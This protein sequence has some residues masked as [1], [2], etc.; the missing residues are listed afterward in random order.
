M[1]LFPITD[2]DS[3]SDS[4]SDFGSDSGSDLP[5]IVDLVNR[6]HAVDG[7]NIRIEVDEFRQELNSSLTTM[8]RDVRVARDGSGR[9]LGLVWTLY[10]PSDETPSSGDVLQRCYVEGCVDPEFRGRGLGRELLSWGVE[11][12]RELLAD[13]P[14]GHRVIRVSRRVDNESAA[15]LHQRF[16]FVDVRW[17]HDLIRDIS[18]S[19]SLATLP[20]RSNPTGI[21]VDPWPEDSEDVLPVKNSSFQDH[22]GSA[23]DT[24]EGWRESVHGFGGRPDLSSVARDT[25]T[26]EIVGFLLTHRYP[27]DDEVNEGRQV[28]IDKLGTLATH[29]G[30]GI[31]SALIIDAIHRYREHGL[32]HAMIGVDADSPTG[33]HRLYRNLGFTPHFSTVTSEIVV[34]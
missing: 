3:S 31:A 27:A 13:G 16:G 23:P 29:R 7:P 24:S 34:T 28:W 17:F 25:T 10:L 5:E 30:R 20:D 18:S 32:T 9:A 33:A 4:N 22:W 15:R 21:S 12:A 11:H 14:S 1:T 2:S 19:E 26:G 6:C 8:E